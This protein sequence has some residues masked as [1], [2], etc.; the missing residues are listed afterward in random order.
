VLHLYD[1][2][3][4]KFTD[5]H[6]CIFFAET[7]IGI[8]D[9]DN[10]EMITTFTYPGATYVHQGWVSTDRTTLYANDEVDEIVNLD[11]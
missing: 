9:I 4:K 6:M 2:P 7:E 8:Y 11:C 1:G 3:D 5:V 10:R